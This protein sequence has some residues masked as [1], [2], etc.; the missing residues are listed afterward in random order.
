VNDSRR[1]YR[2]P[3]LATSRRAV[4]SIKLTA[5]QLNLPRTLLLKAIFIAALVEVITIPLF[6]WLSDFIGRR[7]FYFLGTL[8]TACFAFP[9]RSFTHSGT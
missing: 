9:L 7:I 5:S 8:F 3:N 1:H 2:A 4:C 6:G